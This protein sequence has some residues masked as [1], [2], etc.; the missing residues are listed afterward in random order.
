M[1]M[2]DLQIFQ[3]H[4]LFFVLGTQL[5]VFVFRKGEWDT[6]TTRLFRNFTLGIG[7][8]TA[9]L[10]RGAPE[11]FPTNA[12]ALKTAGSLTAALV[13]GI[14]TSL[15]VYRAAFHRL[16]G[17]KGPFLARLSNLWITSRAVKELHMYTEVQQLHEQ[18]GDIVR[19]AL[20]DYEFRVAD[21]TNQLLASIDKNKGKPF[22]ISDWFN[23]Y[24]FDVMG[25]LA[26]GKSFGM[27]K[28]GIKHYFMTSL[29]QDMQA[30][31]MFSHMLWLFPIFKNTP[32]LNENNKRFWKFVTSQ[33][34]ERI[35]NPPDR[36]D[37]FSW[38]LEEY[39]SLKNPTWQDTLNLYGD[40]YL[41]IVAGSDTT[42]ASLTCLFF[43][44][45]Q[46]PDVYQRLREEIDDYFA[47]NAEPEH[48]ALSKLP[49]LQACIDETLRLHPPV[50]SGVQR[51]TPP[52]GI[53][54]DGTFI[55]G[56]TIIQVPTHTMFRGKSQKEMVSSFIVVSADGVYER[57]FPQANEFI[58]ERWTSRPDL[59]KDP[60]AFVPFGTGK[61]LTSLPP[62]PVWAD[63]CDVRA[64]DKDESRQASTRA[65]ESS[66]A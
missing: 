17:F 38:I 27:L 11:T 54:I 40:A 60:A 16:N 28:E 50:P 26:F 22:N 13:A 41:I 45:A 18:Y 3:A 4:G 25:D 35:A 32:V 24:S 12:A 47:Q 44:L 37:V 29:H 7:L 31:G 9:A 51:M 2:T 59:A 65:S 19:I 15:L 6:A 14:Y 42:A 43:E 39:Q 55:P 48:S 23:F 21:Y 63:R 53:D 34:D 61:H 1:A 30:I 20:R 57:L 8:L 64:D 33:V 62:S 66:W 5:H 56:D 46:K 36:P 10:S 52:E 58:P 49:Y